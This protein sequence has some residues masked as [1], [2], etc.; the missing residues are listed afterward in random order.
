MTRTVLYVTGAIGAGGAERQLLTLLNGLD[1]NRWNPVVLGTENGVLADEFAAASTLVAL[2]RIG[3]IRADIP[4]EVHRLIRE[5]SPDVVHGYLN[6]GNLWSRIVTM[7]MGGSRPVTIASERGLGDRKSFPLRLTDRLLLGATDAITAN[8]RAGARHL[9]LNERV[10]RELVTVIPNGLDLE[11]AQRG[12]LRT[13]AAVRKHR[14]SLGIRDGDIVIGHIGRPHPDKGIELLARAF[15]HIHARY[16]QTKL[17]RVSQDPFPSEVA[18][19]EY[20]KQWIQDRRYAGAVIQHGYTP[21]ISEL[22]SIMDVYIQTSVREGM[23]NVIMEAH[24]MGVPV[25]ATCAG[26]TS[27]LLSH[28]NTGWMVPVG[29]VDGIVAGISNAIEHPELVKGWATTAKRIIER[30]FSARAMSDRTMDLYDGLL[31]RKGI[32]P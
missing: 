27:E 29:D 31:R 19:Y 9:V 1:R 18:T 25:V 15:E 30:H 22:Y 10:P 3:K 32:E 4:H 21:D 12:L 23:P 5:Y 13:P 11:R 24:S 8:S 28:R 2:D 20:F 7:M 16:P 26:G 6:V 17:L 14:E